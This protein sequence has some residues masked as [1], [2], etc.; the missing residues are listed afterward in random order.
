MI[1]NIPTETQ[2]IHQLFQALAPIHI[3][4]FVGAELTAQM[5]TS[6]TTIKLEYN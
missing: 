3:R 5:Q 6:F 2:A 1:L 4:S